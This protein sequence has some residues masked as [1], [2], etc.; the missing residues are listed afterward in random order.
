MCRQGNISYGYGVNK[1]GYYLFY[2]LAAIV[3]LLLFYGIYK[4]DNTSQEGLRPSTIQERNKN[5]LGATWP[6]CKYPEEV[7]AFGVA[8]AV[9]QDKLEEYCKRQLADTAPH[10]PSS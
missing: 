1:A 10:V 3:V 7:A 8:T 4:L 9:P 5:L 2:T 6:D